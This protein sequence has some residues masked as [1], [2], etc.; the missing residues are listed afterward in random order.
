MRGEILVNDSNYWPRLLGGRV[1][2]RRALAAS[3][4]VSL[5]AALLAACGSGRSGGKATGIVDKS[6]LLVKPVDESKNAKHGGTVVSA[7]RALTSLDPIGSANIGINYRM[8]S[9]LWT[10]K[11]GYLEDYKGEIVGD[12]VESWEMSPDKL[13]ITAKITQ[14]AHF[15]TDPPLNGR[16]VD[17]RDVAYTW[18][19]YKKV[20]ALAS[21]VVNENEPAAPVL[22]MAALDDRTV[23]IKLARPDATIFGLLAQSRAGNFY[24]V[25]REAEQ[26]DMRNR[27]IGSGPWMM[28]EWKPGQGAYLKRNPGYHQDHRGENLPYLDEWEYP[29]IS[30]TTVDIEQFRAGHI[31]VW[32]TFI[33]QDHLLS[34]KQENPDLQ[35][36]AVDPASTSMRIIMG[37]LPQSP[38]K[39]DRVRRA[40]MMAFDRD[41]AIET[42]GNTENF[43]KAGLPVEKKWDAPM[44]LDAPEGW[45][46][47]P[48][49]KEFGPNAKN[50]QFDIAEAKKLLAA[51]G[52]PN[53]IDTVINY[54]PQYNAG[55]LKKIAVVLALFGGGPT[56][57]VRYKENLIDYY[58]AWSPQ[59]RLI[60]GQ[61]PDL[62]LLQDVDTP[63]PT[64]YMYSRFHSKG[65]V[66]QGGDSTL[67][68]LLS[69]AV[70]EFDTEK[71]RELIHEVQRY[72]GG[73]MHFPLS[74]GGASSFELHWP[75]VRNLRV[76]QGGVNPEVTYWYDNTKAPFGKS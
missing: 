41:L 10:K 35:M 33:P 55:I 36:F 71:R 25:P 60:R 5:S 62:A 54:P 19:R 6:G 39:D 56:G 28:K 45:Y 22:S 51:A 38:F 26:I 15:V 43:E 37:H 49:S 23:V 42:L 24:V 31:Q 69:K 29:E 73:M 58:V 11:D 65:G 59:Y 75:A 44:W 47:D 4:T 74:H 2:R 76:Y 67:D 3:G 57:P 32:T 9:T 13:Q 68:D 21:E 1:S 27:A 18:E 20:G 48:K 40:T 12:I 70:Q 17:A 63:D 30:E 61:I 8:Y 50:F 7:G 72:E 46:L 66:Y 14:K 53:G 52:F 64:L 16:A 34:M